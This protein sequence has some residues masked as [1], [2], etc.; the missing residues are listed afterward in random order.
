MTYPLPIIG[1]WGHQE[2]SIEEQATGGISL[3]V[4]QNAGCTG[5][6]VIHGG[7]MWKSLLQ[8]TLLP[9]VAW[10]RRDFCSSNGQ[11]PDTFCRLELLRPQ[12]PIQRSVS[13]SLSLLLSLYCLYTQFPEKKEHPGNIINHI[14]NVGDSHSF[15]VLLSNFPGKLH[16]TRATDWS[17]EGLATCSRHSC[18]RRMLISSHADILRPK[19]GEVS[20]QHGI[21]VCQSFLT[22]DHRSWRWDIYKSRALR[23]C[24]LL[25]FVHGI[26]RFVLFGRN[27]LGM[28]AKNAT[29]S[30]NNLKL[31]FLDH[32]GSGGTWTAK[33]QGGHGPMMLDVCQPDPRIYSCPC[34]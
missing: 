22:W 11:S 25:S 27:I 1:H 31:L 19:L 4:V 20:W 10:D 17:V 18:P 12:K 6:T 7:N 34:L 3:S 8:E 15:D 29:G 21:F 30:H 26:S 16:A 24:L 14:T 32:A 23:G 5:T 2:D 28:E 33:A 9:P 13:L